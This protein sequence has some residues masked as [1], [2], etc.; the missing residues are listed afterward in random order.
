MAKKVWP[1]DA[2]AK[3]YADIKQFM[4]DTGDDK[5]IGKISK[6]EL[7][8]GLTIDGIEL[9]PVKGGATS[10]TATVLA[11]GPAGQLRKREAS[12]GWYSANG[13]APVEAAKGKRWVWG[14]NNTAWTL[15]DMGDLPKSPSVDNL[16]ST[17]VEDPLSAN[18]GRVLSGNISAVNSKLFTEASY[19]SANWMNNVYWNFNNLNVGDEAPLITTAAPQNNFAALARIFCRKG[20]VVTVRTFGGSQGRGY[21]VTDTARKIKVVAPALVNTITNPWVYEFVEDGYLY[22]STYNT[23]TATFSVKIDTNKIESA[24]SAAAENAAGISAVSNRTTTLETNLGNVPTRLNG[25]DQRL[26]S[27]TTMVKADLLEAYY[28]A[29]GAKVVGDEAPANYMP[30]TGTPAPDEW[31]THAP[32][33]IF[34]DQ[35]INLKTYGGASGKAY[36][37]TNMAKVITVLAPTNANTVNTPFIHT[38]TENGYLYLNCRKA[39]YD[40]FALTIS[41]DNVKV[42]DA[43]N[44]QNTN[45]IAQNTADIAALQNVGSIADIGRYQNNPLPRTNTTL[46]ILAIGNSYTQDGAQYLSEF[47][48]AANINQ[49]ICVYR[50]IQGGGTLEDWVNN[51]NS[52]NTYSL[53]KNGGSLTMTTTGTLSQILSQNWDVIVIQQESSRSIDFNTFD[54][55]LGQLIRYI[56]K[57]CTNQR[58]ALAWQQVWAYAQNYG[59]APWGIDRF[60]LIVSAVKKMVAKVGIDIIIPTGM[61]IQIARTLPVDGGGKNLINGGGDMC[62]DGLHLGFGTGRYI[63]AATWFQAIIAPILNVRMLGSL[64]RRILDTDELANIYSVAVDDS[65]AAICQECAF[66]ANM[67]M[68]TVTSLN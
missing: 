43:K 34:K 15:W 28:F 47:I 59:S 54:P 65:N 38:V 63:A 3:K 11:A 57:D 18:Q 30:Y 17:S 56:R 62:R 29:F 68:W 36:A 24:L 5:T 10:A 9:D 44:T 16:T 27:V 13:A 61:A 42:L 26:N 49:N 40:S 20:T 58:V 12:P 22:V 66:R 7:K 14:W 32:I 39:A 19:T 8:L 6:D 52:S 25:I 48:N 31:S 53:V 35:V 23:E 50:L 33:P 41:S 2:A 45:A 55:Y 60:N 64:A 21:A 1:R 37:I 67:D 46:R 4:T 51:Y